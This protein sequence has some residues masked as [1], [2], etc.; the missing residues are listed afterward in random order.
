MGSN[1]IDFAFGPLR[2]KGESELVDVPIARAD[3]TYEHPAARS[4]ESNQIFRW[5]GDDQRTTEARRYRDIVRGLLAD[6][7]VE[8][9]DLS[10]TTK[11]QVRNCALLTIQVDQLYAKVYGDRKPA[12]RKVADLLVR[13]Q[14][15]LLRLHISL[16]VTPTHPR[17]EDLPTSLADYMNGSAE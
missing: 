5:P 9:G 12:S 13:Q 1:A 14:A 2:W 4:R 6:M 17:Q 8:A 10:D 7:G 11:T 3:A 15:L 16:G